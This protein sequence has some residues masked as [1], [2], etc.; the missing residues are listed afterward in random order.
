MARLNRNAFSLVA[1]ACCVL[2]ASPVAAQPAGQEM[3]HYF[4]VIMGPGVAPADVKQRRLLIEYFTTKP[5]LAFDYFERP[6]TALRSDAAFAG[7]GKV[8]ASALAAPAGGGGARGGGGGVGGPPPPPPR[9]R[10]HP[11]G[12]PGCHRGTTQPR[13]RLR[14]ENSLDDAQHSRPSRHLARGS[15]PRQRPERARVG[16]RGLA[17]RR[18]PLLLATTRDQPATGAGGGARVAAERA[19]LRCGRPLRWP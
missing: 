19:P 13:P 12:R 5:D 3:D 8:A 1:V 4:S 6:Q 11:S 15:H 18:L 10:S 14:Y 7:M 2:M 16:A 9:D 17:I